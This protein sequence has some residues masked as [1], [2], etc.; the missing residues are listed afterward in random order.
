MAQSVS[1]K[2]ALI[3]IES[4]N[5]NRYFIESVKESNN[6]ISFIVHVIAK[7][8][9]ESCAEPISLH[10]AEKSAFFALNTVED[11]R[12]VMEISLVLFDMGVIGDEE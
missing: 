11:A 9:F 8:N 2:A 10:L 7:K 4:I 3:M 6:L 5:G 1:F 12:D